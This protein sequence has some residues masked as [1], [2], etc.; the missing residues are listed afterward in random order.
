[1]YSNAVCLS[2]SSRIRFTK[3]ANLFFLNLTLSFVVTPPQKGRWRFRN[4][5]VGVSVYN[6][7]GR[8]VAKRSCR[9][10]EDNDCDEMSELARYS[11]EMGKYL[12]FTP[13]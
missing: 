13:S 7:R 3:V 1:M 4:F 12:S 5:L 2:S 6:T 10:L 9:G 8:K 11:L